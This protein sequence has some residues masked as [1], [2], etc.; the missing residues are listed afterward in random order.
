[1]YGNRESERKLK[2]TKLSSRV[3]YINSEMGFAQCWIPKFQILSDLPIILRKWCLVTEKNE[4]KM[5]ENWCQKAKYKLKIT[6]I[7]W[8]VF[9]PAENPD[10]DL[11]KSGSVGVWLLRNWRKMRGN[12]RK[13]GKMLEESG[14]KIW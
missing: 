11:T 3:T 14:V 12:A 7:P 8:W 10:F 13:R 5:R 9:L 6:S 1:M 2:W 4:R